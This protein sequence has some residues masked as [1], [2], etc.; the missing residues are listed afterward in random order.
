MMTA[1]CGTWRGQTAPSTADL[2]AETATVERRIY[3][4]PQRRPRRK[5]RRRPRASRCIQQVIDTGNRRAQ[6]V[7]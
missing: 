1:G 4:Q 6:A 3:R 2:H 7:T 5:P